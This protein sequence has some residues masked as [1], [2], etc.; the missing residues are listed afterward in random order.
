VWRT[1]ALAVAIVVFFATLRWLAGRER[2]QESG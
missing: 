1:L 2:D